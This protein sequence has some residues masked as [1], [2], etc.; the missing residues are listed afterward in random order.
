MTA[1]PREAA[2][3]SDCLDDIAFLLLAL[4]N[5]E[6]VSSAAITDGRVALASVDD[7]GEHLKLIWRFSEA[8]D[9]M[10]GQGWPQAHGAA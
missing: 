5:A 9:S 8:A 3:R 7:H 6:I 4:N 1:V 2:K 10:V